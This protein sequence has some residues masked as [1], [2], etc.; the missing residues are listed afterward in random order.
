M[1][2]ILGWR[3]GYEC[4]TPTHRSW[5]LHRRPSYKIS[6]TFQGQK[7]RGISLRQKS[8]WEKRSTTHRLEKWSCR[9]LV[10]HFMTFYVCHLWH[11]MT[12]YDTS[13]RFMILHDV[14]WLIKTFQDRLWLLMTMTFHDIYD[15]RW[16]IWHF[17]TPHDT[18]RH[19]MTL[20]GNPRHFI[21]LH[22]RLTG[23]DTS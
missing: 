1:K 17:M 23:H 3:M 5:G 13:L 18:S 20:H 14:S 12:D 2:S 15:T 8:S 19:F 4:G 11:L 6:Q 7:I 21:S 22:D 16:L 10:W 9:I